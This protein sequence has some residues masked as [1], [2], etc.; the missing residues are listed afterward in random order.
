MCCNA[1]PCGIPP[2]FGGPCSLVHLLFWFF[3]WFVSGL[4]VTTHNLKKGRAT[5][6]PSA[7]GGGHY[8]L[9]QAYPRRRFEAAAG[10]E[11][12]V[13]VL[14]KSLVQLGL[15]PRSLL[16][17]EPRAGHA[18]GQAGTL[19]LLLLLLWVLLGVR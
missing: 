3:L 1:K 7:D 8:T 14:G 19:L 11:G 9:V 4:V 6:C 15:D 10:E 5:H 12:E 13:E 18:G 2:V 16:I 17:M